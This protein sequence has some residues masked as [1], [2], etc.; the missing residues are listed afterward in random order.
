MVAVAM[1]NLDAILARHSPEPG[2]LLQVLI[3]VQSEFHQISKPHQAEVARYLGVARSRVEGVTAFYAFLSQTPRGELDLRL[4]DSI[5]DQMQGSLVRARRL[6]EA[7]GVPLGTTR[8]DGALSLSLT[9]CTGLC[10]QGPAGLINGRPLTR[11]SEARVE[12][13]IDLVRARIPL[14]DWPEPWF[15]VEH[16]IHRTDVLL[17]D[18][19]VPGQSL[20]KAL[21]IGTSGVLSEM[22]RSGLRGRGGAG[23]TTA[24]KWQ[25]CA[26]S[27]AAEGRGSDRY[28]V[29]NAD[30]GEPGTFK[31]RVLL[32]KRADAV[33]EGM[34]LCAFV[35]GARKGLIYLRGEYAFLKPSLEAVL[36]V[37]RHQGLLGKTILGAPGF[38]FDVE[39]HL[40]AGAYICGEESALIESLE[41]KRGIPRNRPPYPVTQGYLGCPTVVNNVE[42]FFAATSIVR[43]G[44]DWFAARGTASSPGTKLLSLSGDLQRPGIYE[45]PFGTSL[46]TILEEAGA[47]PLLG[48]QVGGPSGVF[49]G[50]DEV[51][52]QLGFEDLATGG[53]LMVFDARRDVLEIVRNFTHFFAH[54]SCGFCTPCRVGT[55]LIKQQFDKIERGQGTAFDLQMLEDTAR[56][57]ASTSHCGLG[58]TAP[59]PILSTLA[60]FPEAYESRLRAKDF[61]PGFDLDLALATAR[62]LTGRDDPGAHLLQD[63][64]E[65]VPERAPRAGGLHVSG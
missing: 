16:P 37:R 41:G 40:G 13:L 35:T 27:P 42:T 48:A 62:A 56:T 22:T 1:S 43:H 29:L 57:I 64:P 7:L 30:E 52:R 59:N 5:T 21:V 53:S 49:V 2:R 50:A 17:D 34:T 39:I 23:Y 3:D 12:A 4:S 47:G 36:A 24:K 10:D 54:E 19:G 51:D 55:S 61:E 18:V 9:S 8:P 14:E 20:R 44:G 28:V 6:S 60:R 32:A 25:L 63:D 15:E 65:S 11:L 33:L 58:Q 45:Y 26:E 38:D 46:R 31:D